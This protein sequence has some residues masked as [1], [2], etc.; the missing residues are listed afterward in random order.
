MTVADQINSEPDHE[1]LT[2]SDPL[3][4]CLSLMTEL[5]D[6][7]VPMSTLKSGFA[8]DSRGHIPRGAVPDV[9]SRYGF[10]AIWVKQRAT[11]FPNY[12]LPVV[13]PLVDGRVVIVRAIRDGKATV[14][15]AETG[16][17]SHEMDIQALDDILT[18]ESLVFKLTPK[19]SKQSLLPLKNEAFS[20]FWSTLW[21]FRRF[22][23][24]AMIATVVANVLT[25]ATV[26]FAMTV[27]NRVIP[28][29]AFTSLWTLTIGVAIAMVL[30]F[31][32]R[33]LKARLVDEG[34]K[35][36]DL[37]VNA[38]LLREIMS[39]RLDHRPQSIGIFASSMRDFDAL[40][41]FMSSSLFVTI[42][43]L[44]FVI[45]FLAIIWLVAGPLVYIPLVVVIVLV[46]LAFAVQPTLMK[47]MR[48]NMKQAGEKQSVLVESLLNLEMLK[49]HNAENYLQRRWEKSNGASVKSFMQIRKVNAWVTGL[50]TTLSQASTVGMIVLGVYLILDNSLSLGGLIAANILVGRALGPVSQLVQLATRY[51]Q[52]KNALEML[53][54]LVQRPRDR[55]HEQ[56]YI[57][58]DGFDGHLMAENVE[59]AYPGPEAVP[60]V[61][62]VSLSLA[63]GERLALLG[64]VG[65]GKSTLLRLMS[66][67]YKPTSGS[68]RVDN[69]DISQIEPTELRRRI[70]YVGQ[71]AQLFMGSL[72]DNLVLS[73]SWITD[74]RIMEVLK[75]LGLYRLVASHPR[76]LDMP[77]TEAGGGLSGGQRQ[78]LSVARMMLRDP[79]YVFMDEP[80]ANM[81]QDT[82]GRVIRV[83]GEWLKGR[84]LLIS[85]HRPQLLQ[86]VDRIGV[87]QKGKIVSQGP[88]D[89]LLQKL[90]RGGNQSKRFTSV[91]GGQS[92]GEVNAA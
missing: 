92:T 27:F 84:T 29:Q 17:R 79:V 33:W 12:A 44:P 18:D 35:R 47:A 65:S 8:L 43:D 58:P 31:S 49:A 24:E 61:N 11:T 60:V 72:R 14:L 2:Q 39:V 34:G 77:L 23:Y 70:G 38:T 83:L 91:Q 55:D 32:M 88:R 53:D 69:L 54:G 64:Q 22:Y 36:A 21:R 75:S 85:T 6:Q 10:Q 13:A 73:E 1:E 48:E 87:M 4:V 89:E 82:E 52:A 59:F 26:F 3:L 37:A 30:E 40:R 28:A 16:M 7:P 68:V 5:L 86:W 25:L 57:V 41:D 9:A 19:A 15:F 66:G 62:G 74:E 78:L 45:L 80:T 81:D 76:G 90:S 67:L 71:D 63:P 50:T 51:Q 46:I 20:W 42:A 56:R